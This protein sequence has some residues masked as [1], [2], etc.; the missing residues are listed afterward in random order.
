MPIVRFFDHEA[1]WPSRVCAGVH[2]DEAAAT[3]LPVGTVTVSEYELPVNE[4]WPLRLVAAPAAVGVYTTFQSGVLR[5]PLPFPDEANA[6][7]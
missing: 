6:V 1:E 2:Q 7:Q 5:P 4:A 3:P